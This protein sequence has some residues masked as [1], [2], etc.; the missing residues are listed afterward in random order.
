MWEALCIAL[1]F[2]E[3]VPLPRPLS[4]LISSPSPAVQ[5]KKIYIYYIEG[6]VKGNSA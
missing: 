2:R 1:P 4:N 3:I 6:K 5:A